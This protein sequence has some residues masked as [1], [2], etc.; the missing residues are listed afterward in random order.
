MILLAPVCLFTR[1]CV[2]PFFYIDNSWEILYVV[3][4][5]TILGHIGE[6]WRRRGRYCRAYLR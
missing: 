4:Y 3:L 6:A 5:H 1:E 2:F